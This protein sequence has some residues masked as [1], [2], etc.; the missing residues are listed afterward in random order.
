LLAGD[1]V[2]YVHQLKA[3]GYFTADEATYAK[4]VVL[5]RNEFLAR[6]RGEAPAPK[7]DIEWAALQALVPTLQ[8]SVDELKDSDFEEAV[9]AVS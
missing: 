2:G 5:L 3:K 4:G 6:L 1:A 7:V 9:E 8:F